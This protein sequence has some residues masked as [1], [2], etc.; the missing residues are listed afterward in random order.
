MHD[1]KY[2]DLDKYEQSA[3]LT[4]LIPG[5]LYDSD[6]PPTKSI[7]LNIENSLAGENAVY[8]HSSTYLNKSG[9]YQQIPFSD[10]VD[11]IHK[12]LEALRDIREIS[13]LSIISHSVGSIVAGG[14]CSRLSGAIRD[15]AAVCLSPPP[16]FGGELAPRKIKQAITSLIG[17]PQ[18]IP[19]QNEITECFIGD[20]G[21]PFFIGQSVWT[22]VESCMDE[23]ADYVV[24]STIDM[25]LIVGLQDRVFNPD[26][27]VESFIGAK[28]LVLNDTHSLKKQGSVKIVTDSIKS[29]IGKNNEV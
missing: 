16:V 8:S 10:Q 13:R 9:Y 22:S 19:N 23:Y 4:L 24:D 15:C 11:M 5:M 6:D 7:L 29:I 28:I 21:K 12:D 25:H 2:K 1:F 20:S 27:V 14:L 26:E 3:E 18:D 17:E